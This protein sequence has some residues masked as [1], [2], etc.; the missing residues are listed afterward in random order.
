MN[1]NDILAMFGAKASV[2]IAGSISAILF[3]LLEIR[4]H[5]VLT[6]LLAICEADGYEITSF[7]DLTQAE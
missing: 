2:V 5:S 7:Q 6:A 3:V 4:Q 1:I